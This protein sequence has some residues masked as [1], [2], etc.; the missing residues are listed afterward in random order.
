[1]TMTVPP[2]RIVGDEPPDPEPSGPFFHIVADH[3]RSVFAV[4]GPMI[5]DG[6][7]KS[8]ARHARDHLHRHVA[9]GPTGSDRVALAAAFQRAK[10]FGGVPPGGI[11]RPRP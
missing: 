10:N 11:L 1:M 4:E 8:A 5:D 6:P 2:L 9:C 3:D 7:W